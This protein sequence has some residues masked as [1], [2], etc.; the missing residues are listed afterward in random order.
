MGKRELL[1]IVGF[2]ILGAVVYQATAPPAGPNERN[3]S[4]SR[5]VDHIRR[6]IRGNR[7]S[8]E[9]TTTR[10]HAIAHDVT[11]LR[12]DGAFA[13]VTIVGEERAD[14]ETRLRVHSNAYD[15]AEANRTARDTAL[16]VD[17]A[18]ATITFRSKYPDPGRQRAFLAMKVPARLRLRIESSPSQLDVTALAAVAVPAG[19]LQATFTRIAGAVDI[20]Q[21]GGSITLEDVGSAKISGRGSEV[22]MSRVRGEVSINMQGGELEAAELAGPIDIDATSADITI[23]KAEHM[24]GPVRINANAGTISVEGLQADARIDGRNAEIEVA[25]TGAAPLAI[26]NEGEERIEVTLPPGS[27]TLDARASNGRITVPEGLQATFNVEQPG[28][29]NGEQRAYGPANGGGPTITLRANHGSIS[30]LSRDALKS[31][32]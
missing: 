4:I 29:P 6:E 24:R 18:G 1:L 2:L 21:R 31:E 14:I 28:D 20:N 23:R 7:A 8:A 11:E 22:A 32:R 12:L 15:E 30:L 26:Y 3:L 16:L 5:L 10:T 17:R 13:E 25:M 27:Y 19:R 9:A